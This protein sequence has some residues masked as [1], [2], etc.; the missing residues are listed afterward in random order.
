M[1]GVFLRPDLTQI[2]VAANKKKKLYITDCKVIRQNYLEALAKDDMAAVEA[3]E[4]FFRDIQ[5]FTKRKKDEI[6][7]V[8]PDYIFSVVDCFYSNGTEQTEE[9]IRQRIGNEFNESYYSTPFIT[10]PELQKPLE[11]VAVISRDI[12]DN[13]IEAADNVK[14]HLASI[15]PASVAF[16][17]S[18]C[19]FNQEQLLLFSF[20]DKATFAAFS[21][22]GGVFKMDNNDLSGKELAAMPVEEAEVVIKDAMCAFELAA[23][24]TFEYLNQNL[25]YTIIGDD[26]VT[27]YDA[28]KT[29]SQQGCK[30][31]PLIVENSVVPDNGFACAAGTLLQDID[32]HDEALQEDVEDYVQ[33][34]SGNVLPVEVQN[35]SKKFY[36]L[37]MFFKLS[38]IATAMLAAIS[39]AELMVIMLFSTVSIPD[40]LQ[41]DYASGQETITQIEKELSI[42]DTQH[43][44][45]QVPLEV[46]SAVMAVKP[47][48]I[49]YTSFEVGSDSKVNNAEWVKIKMVA[50]DPLKFQSYINDL[51]G[52]EMFSSVAIPQMTT[53]N[54]S[55]AKVANLVMGRNGGGKQ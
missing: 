45:D 44:E 42:I 32:F 54:S 39:V 18:Q 28:I 52:I 38:R 9:I 10:T 25:P 55:G 5:S 19:R 12:V 43:K 24:K 7:L 3:W 21:H 1:I 20:A 14:A 46:Y 27:K 53:D 13:I 22:N 8:L 51:S 34:L 49:G 29:R 47:Q 40:G 17:R 35:K 16:F 31:H 48:E 11:S 41:E 2:V 4:Y 37:E 15:E 30:L 26:G 23:E 36:H 33:V 6:F 50:A